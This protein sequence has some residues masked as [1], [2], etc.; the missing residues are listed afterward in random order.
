M[1]EKGRQPWGRASQRDSG[2]EE[3][4]TEDHRRRRWLGERERGKR[5]Q[6]KKKKEERL[7]PNRY[8]DKGASLVGALLHYKGEASALPVDMVRS[9]DPAGSIGRHHPWRP[10]M[11]R[12]ARKAGVQCFG[13]DME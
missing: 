2:A 13:P 7:G 4:R 3:P 10:S 9:S 6:R 1:G 11:H 5:E 12:G 8:R